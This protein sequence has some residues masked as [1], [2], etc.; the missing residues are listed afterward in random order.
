MVECSSDRYPGN[1]KAQ[2]ET[3][4]T[5]MKTRGETGTHT[6]EMYKIQIRKKLFERMESYK[7]KM[8]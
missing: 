1:R 8:K 7:R 6:V 4:E 2:R 5:F 3:R